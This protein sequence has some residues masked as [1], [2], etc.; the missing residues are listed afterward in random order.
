MAARLFKVGDIVAG[1]P[2][3][4]SY[5]WPAQ[6]ADISHAPE[7]LHESLNSQL[8]ECKGSVILRYLGSPTFEYA[9]C[10]EQ[11][12][13]FLRDESDV[14]LLFI[15]AKG[16]NRQAS[17][18][19]IEEIQQL[20]V[21]RR[22][23]D[24]TQ[25]HQGA[26]PVCLDLSEQ[27][28]WPAAFRERALLSP[29]RALTPDDC[30]RTSPSSALDNL[31]AAAR[32]GGRLLLQET[33]WT[34][35]V[36]S[37][38]VAKGKQFLE[39]VRAAGGGGADTL[40]VQPQAGPI[41][42]SE[43]EAASASDTSALSPHE[44][45]VNAD[46]RPIKRRRVGHGAAAA[47]SRVQPSGHLAA[48]ARPLA[49]GGLAG[50]DQPLLPQHGTAAGQQSA[51]RPEASEPVLT[52]YWKHHGHV[53]HAS[54]LHQGE[55]KEPE[56]RP[57]QLEV[58]TDAANTDKADDSWDDDAIITRQQR[59]AESGIEVDDA[60]DDVRST[61]VALQ[62][63]PQ[64]G[65]RGKSHAEVRDNGQVQGV[66]ME[67]DELKPS[68]PI[69]ANQQPKDDEDLKLLAAGGH[70]AEIAL[71]L[72]VTS[73][74]MQIEPAGPQ[75]GS[76]TA[77]T[78]AQRAPS[79]APTPVAADRMA[80]EDMEKRKL[81]TGWGNKTAAE[82]DVGAVSSAKVRAAAGDAE[83][84]TKLPEAFPLA[85]HENGV[86]RSDE[87]RAANGGGCKGDRNVVVDAAGRALGFQSWCTKAEERSTASDTTSEAATVSTPKRSSS[88][89][90]SWRRTPSR[91]LRGVQLVPGAA[92]GINKIASCL[93][94]ET[95]AAARVVAPY[96]TE[97]NLPVLNE[98][99]SQSVAA[100]MA[101]T[102]V[103]ADGDS[104][105][106][107][108]RPA[109]SDLQQS[110]AGAEPSG[111]SIVVSDYQK[112][113]TA[114]GPIDRKDKPY[115]AGLGGDGAAM[116]KGPIHVPGSTVAESGFGLQ[117]QPVSELPAR[118]EGYR[119]L[120]VSAD[121]VSAGALKL[122]R[123][124]ARN[125]V[126][127]MSRD[128]TP[129]PELVHRATL[130]L[131][132]ELCFAKSHLAEEGSLGPRVKKV[133]RQAGEWHDA[134][135]QQ[136][137]G[138]LVSAPCKDMQPASQQQQPC[139]R[140]LQ[141]KASAAAEGDTK[142]IAT[143]APQSFRRTAEEASGRGKAKGI[144]T[145]SLVGSVQPDATES[146]AMRSTADVE[147]KA[148]AQG[149]ASRGRA[150]RAPSLGPAAAGGSSA[151]TRAP[152]SLARNGQTTP[153]APKVAMSAVPPHLMA[154]GCSLRDEGEVDLAS[155]EQPLRCIVSITA[156][157]SSSGGVRAGMPFAQ[158]Q[159]TTI[160]TSAA[161]AAASLHRRPGANPSPA[162]STIG[163]LQLSSL[164]SM[165][166]ATA[167]RMH[168][169][170]AVT[171][172]PTARLPAAVK[173][174]VGQ[175]SGQA[176]ARVPRPH[177][178]PPAP[179]V[180]KPPQ[181]RAPVQGEA[182][183][184]NHL[185]SG[186][187]ERLLIWFGKGVPMPTQT[188]VRN[189]AMM[190]DRGDPTQRPTIEID[191]SS[192]Q[193]C[194]SIVFPRGSDARLLEALLRADGGNLLKIP[195]MQNVKMEVIHPDAPVQPPWSRHLNSPQVG[196][197]QEPLASVAAAGGPSGSMYAG[198]PPATVGDRSR[199]G[200]TVMSAKLP[201]RPAQPTIG[202]QGHH[203]GH[204][205]RKKQAST[206]TVPGRVTPAHHKGAM[207]V[208]QRN[209]VR[210]P[211]AE[212]NMVAISVAQQQQQQQQSHT[213]PFFV[214]PESTGVGR[215]PGPWPMGSS[216]TYMPS[217]EVLGTKYCEEEQL[218]P[219][220]AGG[221]Y[222]PTREEQRCQEEQECPLLTHPPPLGMQHQ[223][224]ASK[225]KQDMTQG[226]PN[227]KDNFATDGAAGSVITSEQIS[228]TNININTSLPFHMSCERRAGF[229]EQ[230]LGNQQ[231]AKQTLVPSSLIPGKEHDSFARGSLHERGRTDA[232]GSSGDSRASL[233]ADNAAMVFHNAG[234]LGLGCDHACNGGRDREEEQLQRNLEPPEV[235]EQSRDHGWERDHNHH[236]EQEWDQKRNREHMGRTT[237]S[238]SRSTSREE[239]PLGRAVN[240]DVKSQLPPTRPL[241]QD[242]IP[243]GSRIEFRPPS[244]GDGAPDSRAP[245]SVSPEAADTGGAGPATTAAVL[246][247]QHSSRPDEGKSGTVAAAVAPDSNRTSA[248]A[249]STP[250]CNGASGL[251]AV[252][253]TW[254]VIPPPE[255]ELRG[256]GMPTTSGA[257]VRSVSMMMAGTA[258]GGPLQPPFKEQHQQVLEGQQQRPQQLYDTCVAAVEQPQRMPVED[259]MALE[260][261]E[262]EG[263]EAAP[264][265][266]SPN[267]APVEALARAIDTE[268]QST[269]SLAE[270]LSRLSPGQVQALG[271]VLLNRM[272]DLEQPTSEE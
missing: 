220:L 109:S 153:M 200:I 190:V 170:G 47:V 166:S 34:G 76:C 101:K 212:G 202:T 67:L 244:D 242:L 271:S 13:E 160:T 26:H 249:R 164:V 259:S 132:R 82:A 4:L 124:L 37:W 260:A 15:P 9:V 108:A 243:P 221:L 268:A 59:K 75:V 51:P 217:Y 235:H 161:A 131:C 141:R 24:H 206:S 151:F 237:R 110:K 31:L 27:D 42:K 201:A 230:Q 52:M 147:P 219:W 20:L 231:G 136:H 186:G 270:L 103:G 45:A 266:A 179:S 70:G 120:H 223:Q 162:T 262:D 198:L 263:Q 113:T 210:G 189:V 138:N 126:A 196:G 2:P 112:C 91:S 89:T 228:T 33:M 240:H 165:K 65:C 3:N 232:R 133:L 5:W 183:D 172:V 256:T 107:I 272:Q 93:P 87:R 111:A 68:A 144:Y 197:Q 180:M 79:P 88:Q 14:G 185:G 252:P 155:M 257:L 16:K 247:E 236:Q 64:R 77:L 156:R 81:A 128:Y 71:P 1:V 30:T 58:T 69:G 23:L 106:A 265:A 175:A 203:T 7:K 50:E 98:G 78:G 195:A 129:R 250:S 43:M 40:S 234:E 167:S 104:T 229:P 264:D 204:R 158:Q 174:V 222:S 224:K 214:I 215:T 48:A 36:Y 194:A 84:G 114:A 135:E 121:D 22:Q 127:V 56:P 245:S 246:R 61:F 181:C 134:E 54:E 94:A 173:P 251:G 10:E 44:W 97:T 191:Y 176:P 142:G 187:A 21:Q 227:K 92:L 239:S 216:H 115:A 226:D 18:Q 148:S 85:G 254:E 145:T 116:G 211:T 208:V 55:R 72:A 119:G 12:V 188:T 39:L 60:D 233:E 99:R 66:G 199:E 159:P 261:L 62:S 25:M 146:R 41:P 207:P 169:V 57:Q 238:R 137:N 178:P 86:K 6:V 28:T 213:T 49:N 149:C 73:S 184:S 35:L 17:L 118:V 38:S 80:V 53:L 140:K 150:A 225:P 154:S 102:A 74:P 83:E 157:N 90:P 32:G 130:L 218:A 209:T 267:C 95:S 163:G 248:S 269:S 8:N 152:G 29:P 192:M 241:V 96:S 193:R 182:S 139:P 253:S 100:P 177:A 63:W 255:V 46:E 105:P 258:T 168:P 171:A 125:P 122:L 205:V 143:G 19:A 11:S 123:R 117:W